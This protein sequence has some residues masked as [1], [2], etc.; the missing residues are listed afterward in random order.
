MYEQ[1]NSYNCAWEPVETHTLLTGIYQNWRSLPWS[2]ESVAIF[3]TDPGSSIDYSVE[4]EGILQP[5]EE[6]TSGSYS[7]APAFGRFPTFIVKVPYF[8][9]IERASNTRAF[10]KHKITKFWDES[11]RKRIRTNPSDLCLLDW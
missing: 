4:A 1:K 2:V 11:I 8:Y 10:S 5:I 9:S 6:P 3:G 7:C